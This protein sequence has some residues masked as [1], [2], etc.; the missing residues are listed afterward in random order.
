ME[1]KTLNT[2]SKVV[3]STRKPP[4]AGKGR[5]KGVPNKTTQTAR[6]AFALFVEGNTDKMQRWL[7]Q[8]AEGVPVMVKDDDGLNAQAEDRNGIPLWI[9]EPSP[10]KALDIIQ[11][12]AEYHV[13]KLART[14]IAGDP[15]MPIINIYKWQDD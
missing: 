2:G 11:K 8:V 6:E 15:K 4:N 5:Q 1:S 3:K 7:E 13:P 12:V 10:D 9:I 14:E